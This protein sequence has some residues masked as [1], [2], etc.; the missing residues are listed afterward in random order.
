MRD[1][2]LVPAVLNY[3]YASLISLTPLPLLLN[4]GE[5]REQPP[6]LGLPVPDGVVAHGV[7]RGGQGGLLEIESN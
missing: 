2:F 5:L 7:R 3:A 1:F 4:E 6:A